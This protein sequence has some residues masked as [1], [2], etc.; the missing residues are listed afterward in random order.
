MSGFAPS[1][2]SVPAAMAR[3]MV[4]WKGE[5]FSRVMKE[6][7]ANLTGGMMKTRTG[8]T[9]RD[10]KRNS[11]TD[12]LGFTLR[13]KKASLIAWMNGSPRRAFTVVPRN[14]KVLSWIDKRTGQR[15]F[16]RVANIPAWKFTPKR[17]VFQDAVDQK[18]TFMERLLELEMVRAFNQMFPKTQ[19]I[20][21][22]F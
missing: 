3:A 12:P 20:W 5:S 13:T 7:E 18:R 4:R 11:K 6:V 19:I 10:V 15:V 2:I 9:L 8:A 17:P 22:V 21:R 16:A 14:K 1:A